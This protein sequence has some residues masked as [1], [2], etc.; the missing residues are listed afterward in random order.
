MSSWRYLIPECSELY[1]KF[2]FG[3]VW[4][5]FFVCLFLFCLFVSCVLF[6]LFASFIFLRRGGGFQVQI[7]SNL[8][9]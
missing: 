4:F 2:F 1:D 6:F 7:P 3:L 5:G 8:I 9:D